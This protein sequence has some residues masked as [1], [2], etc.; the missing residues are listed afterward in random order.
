MNKVLF[1]CLIVLQATPLLSQFANGADQKKYSYGF[2]LGLN[3]SNILYEELPSYFNSNVERINSLGFRI[4]ILSDFKISN[5]ISMAPKAELSFNGGQVSIENIHNGQVVN[6]SVY[7]IIPIS[8]E[9]MTH[10]VF[11]KGDKHWKPYFFVGPNVRL[12]L[13]Q[14]NS[15]VFKRNNADVAID[16]G[17]GAQRTFTQFHFLPELR[18]TFGLLDLNPDPRLESVNFHNVSLI[19]SVMG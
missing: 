9:I 19:F 5:M 15:N 2:S 1:T 14:P 8:A 7:D 16:F 11:K 6:T 12:P 4:G 10:V 17:I 18:Y 3:Y 13:Y